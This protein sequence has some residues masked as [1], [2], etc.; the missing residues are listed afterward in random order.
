[1]P[2]N[3]DDA[4][5]IYVNGQLAGQF[6]Q[7]NAD[8]ITAYVALPRVF[9]LPAN[10]RSG[11]ATIAIRMWMAAF[12]P[13]VDPDAGG[14]H[15]PP[16]LGH[17]SAIDELLKLDWAAIDRSQYD[18]IVEIAILLVALLVAFGLFGLDR[19]EPAYL[20]L[21]LTCAGI[22]ARV[23]IVVMSNYTA[24]IGV[25]LR[26][27]AVLRWKASTS[28]RSRWA[29]TSSRCFRAMTAAFWR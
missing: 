9:P 23:A 6:G 16:M 22:L 10:V 11:P 20:W 4:Y 26:L 7:F 1:M 24:W 8:G 13:M 18:N 28:P 19:K 3:Y 5:Q 2:D 27:F 15:G 21:G 14:L 25:S 17:V 12:T 29:A